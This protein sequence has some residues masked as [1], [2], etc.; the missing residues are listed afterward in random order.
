MWLLSSVPPTGVATNPLAIPN[1]KKMTVASIGIGETVD[2]HWADQSDLPSL[3]L[4]RNV[5]DTLIL[6]DWEDPTIFTPSIATDLGDTVAYS[7]YYDSSLTVE[8]GYAMKAEFTIRTDVKWQDYGKT[9][10]D[11]YAGLDTSDYL[12]PEDVEYSFERWMF[13]DR[14]D[15]AKEKI[16][17]ALFGPGTNEIADLTDPVTQIPAAVGRDDATKKV[18][19]NF[20]N[21]YPL[22]LFYQDLAQAWASIIDKDWAM[23]HGAWDGDPVNWA[24]YHNPPKSPFEAP[25]AEMMGSGPYKGPNPH[26]SGTWGEV[27]RQ[28]K[29]WTIRR[30]ADHWQGWPAPGCSDYVN[31]VTRITRLWADR[32]SLFLSDDPVQADIVWVPKGQVNDADLLAAIGN[33]RVRFIKDLPFHVPPPDPAP[34]THHYERTWVQGWYYNSIEHGNWMECGHHYARIW[35]GLDADV[36]AD[37]KR[38]VADAAVMS[39]HWYMDIGGGN[40]FDG[41]LGYDRKCDIDPVTAPPPYGTG[42]GLAYPADGWVNMEDMGLLHRCFK[43]GPP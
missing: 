43:P 33:G 22:I 40:Y 41:P 25:E 42:D 2:P 3:E 7:A 15:G 24:V 29:T 36:N 17:E 11:P 35:K 9:Y 18:W 1:P 37:G 34:L 26:C 21:E 8:P 5:Y 38:S 12:T 23:A 19:F 27:N 16:F 10:S 13:M 32:K 31:E 20:K 6:F 14:S 39:A 4:V 28:A 30:F